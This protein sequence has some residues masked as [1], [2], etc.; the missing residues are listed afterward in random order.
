MCEFT[1]DPNRSELDGIKG[2]K[3]AH[4]ASSEQNVPNSGSI[5]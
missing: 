4:K 5:I 3:I 2:I 1:G